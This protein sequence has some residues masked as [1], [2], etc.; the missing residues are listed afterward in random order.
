[1]VLTAV[2]NADGSIK[3]DANANGVKDSGEAWEY[4]S[5]PQL[6]EFV[7]TNLYGLV[8]GQAQVMKS[9]TETWAMKDGQR[10][11][12]EGTH[13][14]NHTTATVSYTFNALGQLVGAR[15]GTVG[16]SNSEVLTVKRN[17]DGTIK[18]DRNKDGFRDS[19]ENW[20]FTTTDQTTDFVAT[21]TY[22]VILGQ[23]QVVKSVTESWAMKDGARITDEGSFGYNHTTAT[24]NYTF[25]A[26]GQLIGATGETVGRSNGEVLTVVRNGDG[27]IKNDADKDGFKDAGEKWEFTTTDQLTDFVVTNTYAVI[28]GQAQVVKSV[29]QSWAMKDGVRITNEG[30][31]GYNH[32]TAT[33]NYAFNALG[34]LTGATRPNSGPLEWGSVDRGS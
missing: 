7:V 4:T 19:G 15:G 13:G 16:R 24:V 32:T 17:A 27:S 20:E 31:H 26:V 2:R 3:N 30:T 14:Y 12:D 11:T 1:L 23:A 5:T 29:T 28:V 6:S 25:N 33:V 22:L 8:L 21:N 34:Q 18:N 9:V 10:I